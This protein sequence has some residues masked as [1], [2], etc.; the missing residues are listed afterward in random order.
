MKQT[1]KT[2]FHFSALRLRKKILNR[3]VFSF[4]NIKTLFKSSIRICHQFWQFFFFFA[5]ITHAWIF[6][7]AVHLFSLISIQL[8]W[9]TFIFIYFTFKLYWSTTT[10]KSCNKKRRVF[11][12]LGDPMASAKVWLGLLSEFCSWVLV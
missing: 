4:S 6:I 7:S 9:T 5:N 3:F 2:Y 11:W 8:H 10:N 1:T 12:N